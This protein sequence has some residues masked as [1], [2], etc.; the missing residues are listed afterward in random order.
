MH[1]FLYHQK[2]LW[3]EHLT[4]KITFRIAFLPMFLP[5]QICPFSYANSMGKNKV[6]P[7]FT[8][9]TR[10]TQFLTQITGKIWKK[11]YMQNLTLISGTILIFKSIFVTLMNSCPKTIKIILHDQFLTQITGKILKKFYMQNLT[12]I[13][14]TIWIF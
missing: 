3:R 2:V 5:M 8:K 6:S 7:I 14:G 9:I 4:Q 10:Y 12:L 13:S 1:S 11:F